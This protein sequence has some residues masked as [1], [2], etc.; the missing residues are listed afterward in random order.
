MVTKPN[1]LTKS[2]GKT[3]TKVVNLLLALSKAGIA[4]R[5]KLVSH[6]KT[7]PSFLLQEYLPWI[8]ADFHACLK[9]HW[10]PIEVLGSSAKGKV[11]V[12]QWRFNEALVKSIKEVISKGTTAKTGA[13]E[14]KSGGDVSDGDSDY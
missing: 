5:E 11:T 12:T 3:Q 7:N 8:P 10:P 1:T 2:W 6:W 13:A 4:T 14:S 9:K